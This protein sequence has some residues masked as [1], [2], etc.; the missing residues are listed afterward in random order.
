M[1]KVSLQQYLCIVI[2]F[3]YKT[4]KNMRINGKLE[5]RTDRT[6]P[7]VQISSSVWVNSGRMYVSITDA[8]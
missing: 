7:A 3:L 2:I 8:A 1:R 5:K 6:Y 4:M